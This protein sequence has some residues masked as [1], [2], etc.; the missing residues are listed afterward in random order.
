MLE[1]LRRKSLSKTYNDPTHQVRFE[2]GYARYEKQLSVEQYKQ[3]LFKKNVLESFPNPFTQVSKDFRLIPFHLDKVDFNMILC[4]SGGF[5]MG[6]DSQ[7]DNKP[8]QETINRPFLLGETEITQELYE[9]VMNTNPSNFKSFQNPVEQVSWEDAIK[10]C[11][12]LSQ[13]QDLDLCYTKNSS[14][15]FD[16]L[17]DFDKNGYRLPTEKEWEYAA[18]AGIQNQWS[19]TNNSNKVKDYAWYNQKLVN[20]T[21]PVKT[22]KPNEWGFYDMSGNV[23]EWCWDKY[24]LKDPKLDAYHVNRGGSWNL[25][26]SSVC[27]AYRRRN[28]ANFRQNDLGFRVCRSIVN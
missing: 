10:F 21:Y 25:D 15:E 4:P 8:R 11:N 17:C 13:L 19:G 2:L 12:E 6:L 7:H 3:R 24:D 20:Q 14:K 1:G 28:I 26:A 18:K 16:W 23:F 27:S 22:K 5:T 9:K